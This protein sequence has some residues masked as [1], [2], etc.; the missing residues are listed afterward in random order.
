MTNHHPH[1]QTPDPQNEVAFVNHMCDKLRCTH[2][3]AIFMQLTI[4]P[5]TVHA[6]IPVS[7]TLSL[8]YVLNFQWEVWESDETT[9]PYGYSV[10]DEVPTNMRNDP[11]WTLISGN[12]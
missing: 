11:S 7:T 12:I 9:Y 6:R 5:Y 8:Y 4:A 1:Y 10:W 2:P 3:N